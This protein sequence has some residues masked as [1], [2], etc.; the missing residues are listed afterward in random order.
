VVGYDVEGERFLDANLAYAVQAD[1]GRHVLVVGQ[2]RQPGSLEELSSSKNNDFI[3][4][5]AATNAFATGRRLGVDYAWEGSHRGLALGYHGREL[6]RGQGEGA[7]FAVRGYWAP[8]AAEGNVVHLGLSHARRDTP[9]DTLRLRPNADLAAV[10]L[11]DS[12]R[13]TDADRLATSGIEAMWIRGPLKLQGEFYRSNVE[14]IAADD[15]RI[16]GGYASLLWNPG[17]QTWG[18][19]AGLPRTPSAGG[20][21]A[22][23]W[24]LGLRVDHIDF[25]DGAIRGGRMEAR[26][27]GINWYWRAHAKLMLN[28][29]DVASRRF[30][31]ASGAVVHDDPDILE[32]R[33]QLHW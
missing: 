22:G 6:T 29:V 16:G 7:G 3:A 21:N 33:V 25:D 31:P 12:G 27:V 13:L 14:R 8:V 15:Y 10:R 17:G 9:A 19:R 1:A 32:A 2:S 11:V 5:A 24:Q 26:T 18:Y 28:Y 20:G 23:L 4:K 30:D